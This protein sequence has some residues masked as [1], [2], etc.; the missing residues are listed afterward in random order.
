MTDHGTLA[1]A[2]AVYD[3]ARK[4]SLT[5]ILGL[6]AYVRDDNCPILLKHGV[7]K[8]EKGTLAGYLKYFHVTLHALDQEAYEKLVQVLSNADL[9]RSEQH[10]SERKPLF[11]WEDLETL[12]AQNMTVGSGC[13]VGMVQ[14]H[15]L[16]G[17]PDLAGEYYKR[18]RSIFK[19]G[20][21]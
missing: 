12:G 7:E 8:D 18:L 1:A 20:N 10:G 5:P 16:E 9:N 21:F 11:T 17:R 15:L 19:P 3:T 14:R 4:H 6:E 2:R 13:L